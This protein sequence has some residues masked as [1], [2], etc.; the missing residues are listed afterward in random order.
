MSQ[1]S[2]ADI[3]DLESGAAR[4]E[5]VGSQ[6]GAMRRPLRSQLYSSYW[7]GRAAERFRSEWDTV[8]GP[9]LSRAEGFLR[10]AGRRLRDEADQ[11]RQASNM[12]GG[13]RGATV[14]STGDGGG[15]LGWV[16]DQL[17][18][19]PGF[20]VAAYAP[21]FGL[22]PGLVVGL[23]HATGNSIPDTARILGDTANDVLRE[24]DDLSNRQRSFVRLAKS[25][26]V[27]GVM[28][29]G[30]LIDVSYL[31][32]DAA[33]LGIDYV[34]YGP[35]SQI[36]RDEQADLVSDGLDF[37]GDPLDRMDRSFLKAPVHVVD[38]VTGRD[39]GSRLSPGYWAEGLL[40][41]LSG[42]REGRRSGGGAW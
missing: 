36:V 31:T 20:L 29:L 8:H 11:Q 40:K 27:L 37:A 7:E 38:L 9:A 13:G 16:K 39:Y 2:G 22:V 21:V 26:P 28:S 4:L 32:Y 3:G 15:F 19:P 17:S 12:G 6:I 1:M 35:E 23:A 33:D 14:G 30:D 5:S 42:T 41:S 10:N 34:R 24:S 18:E 25:V